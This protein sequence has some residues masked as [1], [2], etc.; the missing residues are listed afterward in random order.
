MTE[1]EAECQRT[2]DVDDRCG[3]RKVSERYICTESS[4]R[5]ERATECHGDHCQELHSP[6]LPPREPF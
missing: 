4:E 3:K 2:D 6:R 1:G 5:A